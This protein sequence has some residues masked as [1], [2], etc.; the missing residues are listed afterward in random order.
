[1]QWFIRKAGDNVITGGFV[2]PVSK[3]TGAAIVVVGGGKVVEEVLFCEVLVS[4]KSVPGFRDAL[5]SQ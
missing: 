3:K 2:A 4:N 1:M 5:E